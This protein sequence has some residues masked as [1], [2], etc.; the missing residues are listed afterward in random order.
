M[1]RSGARGISLDPSDSLSRA[2]FV[3]SSSTIYLMF[4]YCE[5]VDPKVASALRKDD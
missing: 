1:S 5:L 3:A 4:K 2:I